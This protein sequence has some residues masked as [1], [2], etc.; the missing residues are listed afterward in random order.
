M[1]KIVGISLLSS[2]TLFATNGDNLIGYGSKS[3]ALGGTGIATL[4]GHQIFFQILL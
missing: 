1:K 2:L 4:W 3:R